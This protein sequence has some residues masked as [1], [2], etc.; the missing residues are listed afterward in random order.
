V[1]KK[2]QADKAEE[3]RIAEIEKRLEIKKK[4][5]AQADQK[6]QQELEKKKKEEEEEKR[7]EV[8]AIK[9]KAKQVVPREARLAK[10]T[11]VATVV[12]VQKVAQPAIEVRTSIEA[13]TSSIEAAAPLVSMIFTLVFAPLMSSLLTY[14]SY[15]RLQICQRVLGTLTNFLKMSP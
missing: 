10:Q 8:E 6:R 7:K 12:S 14:S 1:E 13:A 4:E 9:R 15:C 11:A 3:E 5:K 2:K